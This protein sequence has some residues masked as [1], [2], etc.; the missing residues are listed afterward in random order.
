[1]VSGVDLRDYLDF[2]TQA[3]YEA[4]RLTLGYFRTGT[5]QPELKP[6]D[7][8]VTA[9][10]REAERFIR[11]RIGARYPRHAFVG[12]EY[13]AEEGT[14]ASHRWLVDPIDG[15]RALAGAYRCTASWWGW[16]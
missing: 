13:G 7:T 14:D 3:A 12:E 2:A 6:D 10:D 5:M 16:R 15:T 9:A 1:M 11:A 8:P 4:G